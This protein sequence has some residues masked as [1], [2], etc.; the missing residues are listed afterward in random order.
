MALKPRQI[1][2]FRA[3]MREGSMVRASAVMAITQPAISY[4]INSLETAVGFTLF[5]RQG[6]KLSATP[7]ALQFMAEVER[8]YDGL[9]RIQ[10]IARQIANYERAA[11]RILITSAFSAGRIVNGIGQFAAKHPGLKLD[12]DVEQRMN[13]MHR[14]NSGQADLG[15]LSL[16][17]GMDGL[18]VTKLFS[19]ELLCVSSTKGLLEDQ[20][21][22]TPQSL[23]NLPMVA[24]KSGGLIR[25]KIEDW[26]NEAGVKPNYVIEV[27]DAG[28]AIELVKGGLGVTIVSSFSFPEQK[29]SGAIALPLEPPQFIDIGVLLPITQHPNRAV[30]SLVE[31]LQK[32]TWS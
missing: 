30:Q 29:D 23:E 6:G 22:V 12:I 2:A 9:D 27:G 21:S 17:T 8:L 7:E 15:I 24:L 20:D 32:N 5:S 10:E 16:P 13:I 25:P 11:I 28:T 19:T 1:E 4:L 14:I 3:V 18:I 31:F 26:F